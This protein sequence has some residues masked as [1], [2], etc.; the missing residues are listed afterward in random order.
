MLPHARDVFDVGVAGGGDSIARVR[1]SVFVV[2]VF[3]GG[4][5]SV[6][7]ASVCVCCCCCRRCCWW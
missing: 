6:A 7:H 5:D 4:G 3:A 2:V 1:V